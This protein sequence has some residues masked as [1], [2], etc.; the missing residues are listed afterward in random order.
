MAACGPL[1]R[2]ARYH[3]ANEALCADNSGA[4]AATLLFSAASRAELERRRQ[5]C[6]ESLGRE[7]GLRGFSDLGPRED[8]TRP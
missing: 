5:A 1:R 8:E 3:H 6:H 2:K 4:W 7:L